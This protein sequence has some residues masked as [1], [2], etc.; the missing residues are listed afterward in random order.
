MDIF[1][2]K[3]K[4]FLFSEQLSVKATWGLS[5]LMLYV[6]CFLYVSAAEPLSVVLLAV[7]FSET[8]HLFLIDWNWCCHN[9]DQDNIEFL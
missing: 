4:I 1:K 6:K 5:A 2:L 7:S 9:T 8:I 3:I